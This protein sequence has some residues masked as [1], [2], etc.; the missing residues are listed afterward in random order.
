M[1]LLGELPLEVVEALQGL[2]HVLELKEAARQ[3]EVSLQVS[4]VQSQGLQ[5]VP[6]GVV[7]VSVPE[8]ER[9][10]PQSHRSP[11]SQ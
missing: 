11:W 2:G 6:E 10:A 8:G 1:R 4:G 9:A 7:V 5:T 3:P